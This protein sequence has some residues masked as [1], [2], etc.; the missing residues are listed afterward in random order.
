MRCTLGLVFNAES[1]GRVSKQLKQRSIDPPRQ[2]HVDLSHLSQKALD[3][4]SECPP[5]LVRLHRTDEGC[6]EQLPYRRRQAI[7][8]PALRYQEVVA[9]ARERQH[10]V[11]NAADQADISALTRPR[12]H[13][14]VAAAE[15]LKIG[16]G[17]PPLAVDEGWLL[18]YHAVSGEMAGN[19]FS[20]QR[21]V[22]YVAGA[23]IL[24]AADPSR[25]TARTTEPILV[26]ESADETSDAVPNVVFPTAIERIGERQYVFYGMADSKIGVALLERTDLAKSGRLATEVG[27]PE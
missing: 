5:Q 18:I 4:D 24:D 8:A 10:I 1:S 27:L 14:L 11:T 15:A 2:G 3:D 22:R 17:P 20:P 21:N 16:A 7:D 23:M 25:V 26:P 13:R 19:G 12:G 6:I 9:P